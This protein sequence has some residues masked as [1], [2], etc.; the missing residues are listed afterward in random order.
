MSGQT[1][2]ADFNGNSVDLTETWR[3]ECYKAADFF[4]YAS[5]HAKGVAITQ[6]QGSL[7]NK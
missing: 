7:T 4:Q 5:H 6:D 2:A 3:L 1:Q